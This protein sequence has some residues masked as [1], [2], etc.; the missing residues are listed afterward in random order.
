MHTINAMYAVE[1]YIHAYF[2]FGFEPR[3]RVLIHKYCHTLF[4]N[5]RIGLL[6][7]YTL[8]E[9]TRTWLFGESDIQDRLSRGRTI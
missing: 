5:A 3:T 4:T 8:S 9:C 1:L 7:C 2:N 6:G